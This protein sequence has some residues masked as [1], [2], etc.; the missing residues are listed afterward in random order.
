MSRQALTSTFVELN[1][2]FNSVLNILR[3]SFEFNCVASFEFSIHFS[4]AY[5]FHKQKFER[6]LSKLKS[7]LT[8][9]SNDCLM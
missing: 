5:S 7:D 1:D 3:V 2:V 9:S 8:C 6:F 4:M